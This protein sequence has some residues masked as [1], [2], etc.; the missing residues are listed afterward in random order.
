LRKAEEEEEEEDRYRGGR[1]REWSMGRGR[2]DVGD[3]RWRMRKD[4]D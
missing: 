1:C 3:E 4:H 2:W